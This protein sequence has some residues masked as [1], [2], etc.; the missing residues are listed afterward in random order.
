MCIIFNKIVD[1]AD[2]LKSAGHL[3]I[4]YETSQFLKKNHMNSGLKLTVVLD[5][6]ADKIVTTFD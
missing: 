3:L 5:V 2:R 1:F 6:S 4:L